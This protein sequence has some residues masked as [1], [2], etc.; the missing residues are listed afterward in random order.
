[1]LSFAADIL[2]NPATMYMADNVDGDIYKEADSICDF[3]R[4]DGSSVP[5]QQNQLWSRQ[6]TLCCKICILY[7]MCDSGR[8]P[9][10]QKSGLLTDL[11][12]IIVP[13]FK[14]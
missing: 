5:M 10:I 7:Q 11:L 1:M 3:L 14:P 12:F 4:M 9:N 6:S 8:S 13:H 2:L